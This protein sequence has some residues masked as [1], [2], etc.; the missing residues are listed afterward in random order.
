MTPTDCFTPVVREGS[1]PTVRTLDAHR[2]VR[3]DG[4]L[5]LIDEVQR[6]RSI[7]EV[8]SV[9][10]TRWKHCASINN[11]RLLCVYEQ[12]CALVV[13][14]GNQ[15]R[16]TELVLNAL[17]PFDALMWSKRLPRHLTT[18]MLL[19]ERTALP[20]E[21]ADEQGVALSTLPIQQ[22]SLSIGM[23]SVLTFDKPFD[24]LDR[25][26]NALVA[27][28]M[29]AR[30][31]AILTE[32]S[33][34]RDLML[35][36]R[37]ILEQ[38][39]ASIMGRLVN[40]VA[41]EL[42]TPLGVQI[43]SCDALA[44][45]LADAESAK[46]FAQD[47]QE[48]VALIEQQA[49]RAA[50]IVRRLKQISAAS[51]AG[52]KTDTPLL[53]E[54]TLLAG[55]YSDLS[56]RTDC[57]AQLALTLDRTALG[58]VLNELLDN[59]R[60]HAACTP[61][62]APVQI[63]ATETS[64]EVCIGIVDA[65]NGFAPEQ[66][67]HFCD[68]FFTSK[69]NQGH[70]GIG[71]YIAYNV[72][73][74]AL[75]AVM[76]LQTTPGHT[77]VTLRFPKRQTK[78]NMTASATYQ[79]L[80]DLSPDGVIMVRSDGSIQAANDNLVA[81]FGYSEADLQGV[82]LEFLLPSIGHVLRQVLEA[83]S[84][85][86]STGLAKQSVHEY[87]VQNAVGNT[88]AVD[89]TLA[90]VSAQDTRQTLACVSVR[91][92]TVRKRTE[93]ALEESRLR[94]DRIQNDLLDLSNTLP[95]ALFQIESDL[96]GNSRYSFISARVQQV[97]GISADDLLADPALFLASIV[98]EDALKLRTLVRA[99]EAR[100]HQ[101]SKEASYT[102]SVR[103]PVLGRNR[104]IT[105]SAV[106]G[107]RR[108][109]GHIVWNGYLEDIS[110][111]KQMEQGKELATLQFKTLWEK[112]PHTYLFRG[113]RGLLSINAP[114][115]DLFGV[116]SAAEL[117]GH[118]VGDST[119]SPE[120]QPNGQP[121]GTLFSAILAYASDLAHGDTLAAP[122][123]AGLS[124]SVVRGSLTLEWTLLRQ[125]NVPFVVEMVVT[126]MHFDAQDGHLLICQDISLQKQAQAELLNAK[127]IAEDM[128]RTKADFLANMSHEIRTP[129][130]AIVGLSHLVLR[131]ELNRSQREFLG[132]I[133]DS[134]Q[135]LLCIINDILDVSKMEAG[136]LTL[137]HR[138]FEL[139][140]VL[141][142]VTNLIGD[143]ATA[144]ELELI[145]DVAPGVPDS[146]RGDS[147]RLGQILINYANNAIK[148]T[149]RGEICIA[150]T[151][152]EQQGQQVLLRFAVRDTGIGLGPEQM[153][154]LFQSFQQADTS[155]TRK[156]GGTGLG[157][158]ISKSLAELMHGAVGV[159]SVLGQGSTFWFTAQMEIGTQQSRA[160][161]PEPDLCGRRVLV[162]DDNDCARLVMG[163][164]LRRMSFDVDVLEAGAPALEAVQRAEHQGNPYE[165]VFLDWRMDAMDGVEVA[166]RIQALD[167]AHPPCVVMVTAFGREDLAQSAADAGIDEILVKP[168]NASQLFDTAMHV[169]GAEVK[170][171]P[172]R[173]QVA[174]SLEQQL[175]TIAGARVLLVEDNE[176]NQL[177]AT[178]LL[179]SAGLE[180]DVASDGRQAVQR[181]LAT[182]RRW[183][184][185]LMDMQMPVLDGVSATLEI[186]H[187][188]QG[189]LP[190]IVAMTA[191][192]MPQHVEKCLG[193]GMQDFV[194]KPID[195]E[196]LWTTLIRW[197]APRHATKEALP[198]AASTTENSVA[199]QWLRNLSGVPCLDA[200]QGLRR[201]MGKELSYLKMLRKFV[202]S[203]HDTMTHTRE[204]LA[205]S[206]WLTAERIAHTLKAVAGNIGASQ[207]QVDA[208]ALETALNTQQAL[209]DIEP[210][211][212]A[213]S[214]SLGDLIALL[215]QHLPQAAAPS[216]VS[217]ADKGRVRELVEKIKKLVQEDDATALDLFADNAAL[218]KFTYPD[219]YK[220]LDA[221]L[222][223]YD[224]SVA[225]EYLQTP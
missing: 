188:L 47:I 197:I 185:V 150:V 216:T 95:L 52:P 100:L 1:P 16:V 89:V 196:L 221:A 48:T 33:L 211:I 50:K 190:V 112:S 71:G 210:L 67:A 91:D 192:A 174:S 147:L 43:A 169:L 120:F 102:L 183:D 10:A 208:A 44:A 46:E 8:A 110:G 86:D 167:L 143:K 31:L 2:A 209:A 3:Y 38:R 113:P 17:E 161:M 125:G 222:S 37:Q 159:E 14:V 202:S 179:M 105:V 135:H 207:I 194:S 144:K 178:E 25:K 7:E 28:A 99:A 63:S 136:K 40:G 90:R 32:Q 85:G 146:L 97:M 42:N 107:G 223:A 108:V 193:A 119:F 206:D 62:C 132:K 79:G 134:S 158:A 199:P 187:A 21:L 177:V 118:C 164:L 140:K 176:L 142:N 139:S 61:D 69:L 198:T 203:H 156:Y 29:A 137:E 170:P 130:N 220:Q 204:A 155:I 55:S 121:S 124:H 111:R 70:I 101:G 22:G 11:W 78:F 104:W 165:I 96:A 59:V 94:N 184:I 123:L 171:R 138:D 30:I 34:T 219:C 72:A 131:S 15:A 27:G 60:A 117:I 13:A 88:L 163:D 20:P 133:Q 75:G 151:L 93:Q 116:Y 74:D 81:L 35:A 180:V 84:D 80:L 51:V 224:F 218:M 195:P 24:N 225:L 53:E 201:V 66:V 92:A 115:L 186:R 217:D 212:A 18:A 23:L 173:A 181:V 39:Q 83:P 200:K 213:A 26:F 57:P 65:G 6:R 64:E 172:N 4:L 153:D 189:Q 54:L 214:T 45:M 128:A 149:H 157:L 106:F 166:W 175:S 152:L 205:Q 9:V 68:P 98:A 114:A 168:V 154:K 56:I 36:Q 145:F 41:H 19:A 76:E 109:N 12:H 77:A 162:V 58:I 87:W 127:L 148:F 82:P 182:P 191:N 215:T 73:R 141:D 160:L 122:D 5:Q 129:M 126:P 49:R 103:V